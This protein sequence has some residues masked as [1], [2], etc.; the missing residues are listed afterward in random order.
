MEPGIQFVTPEYIFA[1][2]HHRDAPPLTRPA[3]RVGTRDAA[4]LAFQ[5]REGA[6]ARGARLIAPVGLP[7]CGKTTLGAELRKLGAILV[8]KD[9]LGSRFG[10]ELK[11]QLKAGHLVVADRTNLKLEER[12]FIREVAAAE[13]TGV[14]FVDMLEAVRERDGSVRI[15]DGGAWHWNCCRGEAGGAFV[16]KIAYAKMKKTAVPVGTAPE[17]RD[18]LVVRSPPLIP[19]D[20][21]RYFDNVPA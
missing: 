12:L 6:G 3:R 2:S 15:G 11:T 1:G 7:G 20:D 13:K 14:I 18:V 17:E 4:T 5:L 8:S 21:R 10:T 16:P 9:E 19:D